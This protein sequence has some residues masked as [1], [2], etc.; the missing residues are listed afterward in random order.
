MWITVALADLCRPPRR[1]DRIPRRAPWTRDDNAGSIVEFTAENHRCEFRT[2]E[3]LAV[4][5]YGA[6]T[7][8]RPHRIYRST[9]WCGR[10]CSALTGTREARA[11]SAH[12]V[13]AVRQ[14]YGPVICQL[15]DDSRPEAR[16]QAAVGCEESNSPVA[17]ALSQAGSMPQSPRSW[18]ARAVIHPHAAQ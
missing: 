6:L 8:R 7:R 3:R 15:T 14:A 4:L 17:A 13:R 12:A 1:A 9:S 2:P 11:G 10:L 5:D 16:G 18:R